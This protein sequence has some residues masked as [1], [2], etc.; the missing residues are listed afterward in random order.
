MPRYKN[1]VSQI[2]SDV[3]KLMPKSK[4]LPHFA[5]IEEMDWVGDLNPRPQL[6][7]NIRKLF[8]I[9]LY[10]CLGLPQIDTTTF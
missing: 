1:I 4:T 9:V 2:S 6:I 10:L 7:D 8:P 5:R 3:V